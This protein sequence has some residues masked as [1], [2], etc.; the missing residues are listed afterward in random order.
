MWTTKSDAFW[1]HKS[2]SAKEIAKMWNCE[3]TRNKSR[4]EEEPLSRVLV[5][6]LLHITS[7]LRGE[8]NLMPETIVVP[9]KTSNGSQHRSS[10]TTAASVSTT[11]V[12]ECAGDVQNKNVMAPVEEQQVG[13]EKQQQKFLLIS[14]RTTTT[15][16]AN[17]D[18]AAADDVVEVEAAPT[19]KQV[20]RQFACQKHQTPP[21]A[22]SILSPTMETHFEWRQQDDGGRGTRGRRAQKGSVLLLPATQRPR[23]KDANMLSLV[24]GSG[25]P[26]WNKI[27]LKI[28]W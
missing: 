12:G 11:L 17:H 20:R 18:P 27:R 26:G 2:K 16:F 5:L 4:E 21:T 8:I 19:T 13:D 15:V 14:R 3:S 22:R 24:D 23:S 9:T 1:D 6:L 28:V 25:A 10:G 7:V